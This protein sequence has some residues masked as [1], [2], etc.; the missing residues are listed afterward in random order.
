[1]TGSQDPDA[2]TRKAGEKPERLL[3]DTFLSGTVGMGGVGSAGPRLSASALHGAKDEGAGARMHDGHSWK[4]H[5]I[6]EGDSGDE[7]ASGGGGIRGLFSR[8]FGG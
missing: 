3:Q 2:E 8:L 4:N 7:P 1:V 6:D 5:A